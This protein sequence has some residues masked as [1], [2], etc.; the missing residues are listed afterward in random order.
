[1]IEKI[2]FANHPLK[3]LL[4]PLL[5]PLSVLF[6][7]ISRSRRDDYQSGKRTR[8]RAPVPVIVVGN[9]TAGGNG[10]TPVVI[11]LVE[12][13]QDLGYK[14]GV[15]SRGYGAKAP[16]YPLVVEDET[17]TKHCGD[18]P[19][20]I[21]KRT[22]APVAVSPKRSEAVQALLPLGVDII[23]T[24]DGLQ[25]YALQRDIEIVVVDGVR[26]FGNGSLIPLGPLRE[27]T[28]RLSEVDFIITNGG[29][30]LE[31]EAAMTLQ[32]T[33]AVNLKSGQRIDVSQLNDRLVAMAG[34]GHPPR[35]FNTLEQLGAK[36]AIMQGFADHKDFDVS[37][38]EQLAA[39]GNHLIMTEKDAVKCAHYA[40]SNWWYLPVSAEFSAKDET[41]ILNKIKEV[42][43][44]YGSSSA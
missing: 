20:L 26:R 28:A 19:K 40:Q 2:W 42:K 25:H 13:L 9:I 1:M 3:Y 17:S 16:F 12:K 7:V 36:P 32:P 10:K 44:Q 23:I 27:S 14:P 6:G 43:E 18:E 37:E 24:D 11:W 41:R 21:F 39:Q 33:D 22:G 34:I 35:F 15:V 29:D 5:W 4:W 38:L 30:A 8:Y 31:D